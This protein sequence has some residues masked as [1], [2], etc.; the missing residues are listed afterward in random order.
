MFF[1]PPSSEGYDHLQLLESTFARIT[2]P[3]LTKCASM[4]SSV[5]SRC[6]PKIFI[7]HFDYELFTVVFFIGEEIDCLG[8]NKFFLF[9]FVIFQQEQ[10]IV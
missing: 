10:F 9:C 4:D 3:S 8:C 6:H 2:P 5:C 1:K 7:L